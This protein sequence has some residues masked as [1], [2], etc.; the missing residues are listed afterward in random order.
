MKSY[1]DLRQSKKLAEILPHESA[2]M[3]WTE[4]YKGQVTENGQYIVA[5]EPCYYLS[6][7]K[8]SENN[9]SQDTI[10]DVPCW[11]LAALLDVIPKEV[12]IKG[13][14]YTPCLFP[15][16]DVYWLYKLWYNSN[17]IKSPISIW[18]DNPVD[19]CCEM[20]IK[21]HELNLL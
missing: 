13:Q 14:K 20:I 3:W 4:R 1:T 12:K 2:D 15:I 10:K 11:S 21:L 16:T 18:C 7:I 9:Y 8:P 5:E 19:A 6:F 17:E